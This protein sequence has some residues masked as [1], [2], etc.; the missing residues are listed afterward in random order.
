MGKKLEANGIWES[1]R[2][3][4]PEHKSA[5][6]HHAKE[7]QRRIK[8]I[9]DSQETEQIERTLNES[10]HL[11]IS[12]ILRIFGEYEDSEL[13][14]HVTSIHTHKREIKFQLS[15]DWEWIKIEDIIS[16]FK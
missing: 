15:D 16:A 1:S 4:I 7:R 3:I 12:V 8:P 14:G 5:I 9:L 13:K 6:L 10:L 2:I 11:H